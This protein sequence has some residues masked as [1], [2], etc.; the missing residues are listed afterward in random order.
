MCEK[1]PKFLEPHQLDLFIWFWPIFCSTSHRF[2]SE[3]TYFCLLL[4]EQTT[5]NLKGLLQNRFKFRGW[6]VEVLNLS[7]WHRAYVCR[8]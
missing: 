3:Q 2:K 5:G 1:G 6:Q 4:F 8:F 7:N